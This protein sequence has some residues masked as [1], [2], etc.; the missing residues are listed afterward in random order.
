MPVYYVHYDLADGFIHNWLVGGPQAILVSDLDRYTDGDFQQ[1]ARRYYEESLGITDMPIERGPLTEEGTFKV[2]DLA[3]FKHY[4]TPY[5]VVDLPSAQIEVRSEAY[6]LRLD[7]SPS[8][9][10]A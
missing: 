1:I 7:L 9:S 8:Q 5:C 2:R 3:G 6:L 4:E 10:E